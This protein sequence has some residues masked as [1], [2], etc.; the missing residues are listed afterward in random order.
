M[1]EFSSYQE[2]FPFYVGQH[3]RA[4]TRWFHFAGTHLGV[5]AASAALAL[6]RPAG[7]AA[8]PVIAYGLAWFSHFAI[9]KNRPAT[10]GHPLWSLRGD[11]QMIAVMWQGKDGELDRIARGQRSIVLP[12]DDRS[13]A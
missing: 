13:A 8:F 7:V 3:S 6:R 1:T 11:F 4:A 2:F 10:F 12:E 9:E 5:L